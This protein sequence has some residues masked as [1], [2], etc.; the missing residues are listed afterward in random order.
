MGRKISQY[1]ELQSYSSHY[2]IMSVAMTSSTRGL[3]CNEMIKQLFGCIT[4]LFSGHVSL[5]S[6]LRSVSNDREVYCL[7]M[8]LYINTSYLLY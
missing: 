5:I 4:A 6:A 2:S 1:K 8:L 3:S 7:H